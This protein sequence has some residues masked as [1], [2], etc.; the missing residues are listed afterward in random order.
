[1]NPTLAKQICIKAHKGQF[2]NSRPTTTEERTNGN[3]IKHHMSP[4]SF[5]LKNGNIVSFAP[6]NS[7]TT[8]EPY[9]THPIAVAEMA[10]TDDEKIIG[11]LHDVVEDTDAELIYDTIQGAHYLDTSFGKY[12]L[13]EHIAEALNV[14][15]KSDDK[16][17]Y[18]YMLNLSK[19]KLA[20]KVKILDMFHNISC[21]PSDKQKIKY[22]QG[23]KYLLNTL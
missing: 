8:K 1:M 16:T 7:A 2:R 11:Y 12:A 20:T 4:D 23:I 17:Y 3:L 15:T 6:D 18:T 19:C 10:S 9:H 13:M 22:Y 5:L 14:I 21:S